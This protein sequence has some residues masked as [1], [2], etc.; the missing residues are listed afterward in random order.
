MSSEV[1]MVYALWA[2]IGIGVFWFLVHNGKKQRAN[3]TVSELLE[4]VGE[5]LG[6]AVDHQRFVAG[7]ITGHE[8]WNGW[9]TGQRDGLEVES[10]QVDID[11]S[12]ESDGPEASF[13][14][15]RVALS[16]RWDS[17]MELVSA[18]AETFGEYPELLDPIE[19]GDD[20]FDERFRIEVQLPDFL[21]QILLSDDIQS[22]LR[23]LDDD[24]QSLRIAGGQLRRRYDLDTF[25]SP[26]EWLRA[27]DDTVDAAQRLNASI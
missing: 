4:Q 7:D 16:D 21:E 25:R 9:I 17:G 15:I 10:G 18:D 1:F 27:I 13:I 19:T 5:H 8:Y 11:L 24:C 12:E 26:D 6:F 23:R 20:A 2:A 3:Q 14:E 22:L